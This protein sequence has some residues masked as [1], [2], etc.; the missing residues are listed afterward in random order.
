[1]A[2]GSNAPQP[3]VPKP[4]LCDEAKRTQ[5]KDATSE[6]AAEAV[7]LF[8]Y[9]E[10]RCSTSKGDDIHQPR[11]VRALPLRHI[12]H[13]LEKPQSEMYSLY[14]EANPGGVCERIFAGL[15]PWWVYRVR[16]CDRL[17][18]QC[19]THVEAGNIFNAFSRLASSVC[20]VC[21]R[22]QRATAVGVE[23]ALCAAGRRVA[24]GASTAGESAARI[25]KAQEVIKPV[26]DC[27]DSLNEFV[28]D[29]VG[30]FKLKPVL[31]A[32]G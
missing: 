5:R 23:A 16:A 27:H 31:T 9:E 13:F 8:W 14:L 12:K 20:R 19:R 21:G 17:T 25:A 24:P 11:G 22:P 26:V 32:P 3:K 6:A 18:C 2:S 30:L 4:R 1:V 29:V 15:K 28:R 10:T 7:E